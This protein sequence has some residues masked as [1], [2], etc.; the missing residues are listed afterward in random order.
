MLSLFRRFLGTFV[1]KLFFIV[2]VASF[3]LWGVADV[4]RNL[5][6]DGA[7]AVVG[8]RKIQLP[9]AQDAY[10][11]Q[12]EQVTKMFGSQIQPTPEIKKSVAAQAV[13]RLVTTAALDDEVD[14]LG[15]TVTDAAVRDAVFAIPAFRGPKGVFDRDQFNAV[16][17]SNGY[18][19]DR[20]LALMRADLGEKQLLLAV[21]AGTMAPD[22]LVKQVYAFQHETREAD[23]VAFPFG[24]APD[25][26]PPTDKQLQRYYANNKDRYA[27]PEYRR[28]KAVVLTPDA[29]IKDVPVSDADITA[30]YDQHKA[31]YITPEKR[32]VQVINAQDEAT[33]Q[34]LADAWTAGASWDDI[35]KQATAAGAAGVEL[36]DS[37]QSEFPAPELGQAVFAAQPNV[38][39]TPIHSALGWHVV[40]VT[41]I[42]PGA[43]RSLADVKAEITRRIATDKATDLL[44]T[45]ANKV[46]DALNAGTSLDDLPGDLGLIAVTGTL[47]AQGNK[48]DGTPAP[49]P[50]PAELR[51]AL[52]QAAFQAKK[53]DTPNFVQAPNAADGSQSFYAV[54][55]EDIIPPSTRPYA[56]VAAKVKADWTHDAVR[57]EQEVAAAALLTAVKGGATLAAAAEAA[58]LQVQALPAVGR[59]S[60][61]PGVATQLINPLFALKPGEPTM[62]ETPD[63]FL[64]ATLAK[65]DAADPAKDPIGL[66]QVRDALLKSMSD[67]I[68]AVFSTAV[69]DRLKPQIN[70]NQLDQ[71]VQAE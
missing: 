62:V 57:H 8:A 31:E 13:E 66:G 16:L 17:R 25:P 22:V 20:F 37:A 64:V 46:E 32:S 67:D 49:I 61:A 56:E 35:Q 30:F 36:D 59:A 6:S 54:S 34:K 27:T 9:E 42:K 10:R 51:P 39:S 33:A 5:G 68:E 7:L 60:P 2:L 43:S 50:G 65:I 53:G 52:L 40:K 24:T 44:Y 1:A 14:N 12:L 19:E 26:A 58:H 23:Q 41:A 29:L 15:L 55:V 4:I 3:G 28:I 69:R 70:R 47:D 71:M 63:G 45:R 38:I 11:R 21:R 48:Q 18:S